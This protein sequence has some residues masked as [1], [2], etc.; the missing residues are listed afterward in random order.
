MLQMLKKSF[1]THDISIVIDKNPYISQTEAS[2]QLFK[3][4]YILDALWSFRY[5]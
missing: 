1:L 3:L 5:L 4:E 2:C